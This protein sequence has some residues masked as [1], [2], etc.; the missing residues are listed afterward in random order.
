MVAVGC[1]REAAG[2]GRSSSGLGRELAPPGE[3]ERKG[4]L[5]IKLNRKSERNRR[6]APPPDPASS[7]QVGLGV[8]G[9]KGPGGSSSPRCPIVPDSVRVVRAVGSS[10]GKLREF[11]AGESP[12]HYTQTRIHLIFL[13]G[14][15]KGVDVVK[16]QQQKRAWPVRNKKVGKRLARWLA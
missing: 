6:P 16:Q 4:A 3:W 11:E 10:G 5:L 8:E 15:N 13:L 14:E 7:R 9:W 12:L 1:V 2:N